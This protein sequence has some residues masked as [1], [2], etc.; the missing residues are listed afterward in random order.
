MALDHAPDRL[1]RLVQTHLKRYPESELLDMYKLLHQGVFGPGHS[2]PDRKAAREWLDQE[3]GQQTPEPGLLIESVHP[4]DLIVRLHLRPYLAAKG[5]LPSLLEAYVKSGDTVKGAIETM[6]AWWAAF[7]ALIA[8]GGLITGRFEP[9]TAALMG[10]TRAA[11]HWPAMHHSPT[12]NRAYR[13][14]YRVLTRERAQDLLRGQ[15]IPFQ[16]G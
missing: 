14:V 6:A 12:F 4:D 7:S 1:A 16:L 15:A 11:E 8:S 13:P 3:A 5:S 2:I 9:R 10:R